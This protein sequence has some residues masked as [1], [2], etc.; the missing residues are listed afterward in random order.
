MFII[1]FLYMFFDALFKSNCI[2]SLVL[3]IVMVCDAYW[4]LIYCCRTY[5]SAQYA[6]QDRMLT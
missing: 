5:V 1:Y 2:G 4:M 3:L 6:L